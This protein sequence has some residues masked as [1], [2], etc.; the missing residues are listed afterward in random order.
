MQT[1]LFR[2]NFESKQLENKQVRPSF[3]LSKPTVGGYRKEKPHE[4]HVTLTFDLRL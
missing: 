2:W 3:K 1:V 4:T